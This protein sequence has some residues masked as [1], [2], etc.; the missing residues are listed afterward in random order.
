MSKIAYWA[1]KPEVMAM[2]AG[3]IAVVDG[4]SGAPTYAAAYGVLFIAFILIA[5][6]SSHQ[7]DDGWVGIPSREIR[8]RQYHRARYDE[9][10][11]RADEMTGDDA[12]F[13]RLTAKQYAYLTWFPSVR[14]GIEHGR[15]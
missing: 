2:A 5:L 11:A 9:M 14:E 15:S 13:E 4:L 8:R 6:H 10:L 12:T 3:L 7:P 1:D